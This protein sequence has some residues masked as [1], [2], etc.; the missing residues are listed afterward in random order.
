MFKH[1]KLY[2][3]VPISE[4]NS[5]SGESNSPA[6]SQEIQQFIELGSHYNIQKRPLLLHIL[7]QHSPQNLI[8]QGQFKYFL[9]IRYTPGPS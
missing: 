8:L 3:K 2:C 5:S 7:S 4:K 6:A 9:T 1:E